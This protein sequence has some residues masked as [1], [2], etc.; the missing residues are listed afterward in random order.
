MAAWTIAELPEP[1]RDVERAKRDISEFGY[2]IVREAISLEV[3]AA[4]RE[5][6]AEQAEAERKQGLKRLNQVQDEGNVNQWVSVLVNKGSIF[7]KLLLNPQITP[8]LEHVLGPGALLSDFSA[9]AVRPGSAS[10]P[11]HIDQWWLP[12][13][14][15]PRADYVRVGAINRE[16]IPPGD[17]TP[18]EQAINPPCVANVFWMISDFTEEN[19][20]PRIVPRSHLSGAHPD[21]AVPHPVDTVPLTG[22]AG[23]A[24]IWEGRTWHAAGANT[25]DATRYGITS[26]YGGPQFRSLT[27]FT[28]ASHAPIL[29][30]ASPELRTLLGFKVWN[31][32]G[33]TGREIDGFAL[34]A[35]QLEGELEP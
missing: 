20:A 31:E 9:H 12:Q 29:A 15:P 22:P 28:L 26:Y 35:D 30:G 8:V 23:T 6:V 21:G 10:L 34:A 18:T 5:R 13:P 2:C 14:R 33:G 32:Y 3:A 19:G 4:V 7:Q 25:S 27:N 16:N 1:T 17:P 24:V 11:L